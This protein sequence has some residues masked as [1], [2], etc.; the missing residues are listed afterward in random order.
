M[1]RNINA[2]VYFVKILQSISWLVLW[3]LIQLFVGVY[4]NYAF[5]DSSPTWINIVYYIFLLGSGYFVLRI[6]RKKWKV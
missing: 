5:F 3:M 6:I 4:L 2:A 1:E